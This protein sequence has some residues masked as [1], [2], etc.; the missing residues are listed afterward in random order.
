MYLLD[1]NIC[2]YIIN[3]KPIGV[4][5]K[6]TEIL[7]SE[8]G[9]SSITAAE[10][11]FGVKKSRFVEQNS[12]ALRLFLHPLTI[13]PFDEI[14]AP[15]YGVIRS[16]LEKRGEVIGAM[17]DMLIAAHALA[18]DK[19]LVTNNEREFKKVSGL[20]IENWVNL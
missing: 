19:I 8:I 3:Q 17:V 9:I 10:L 6:M 14:C 13:Y 18:L 5:H 2:I 4:L 12:H 1:T 7:P 16:E 20:K 11:D 15:H